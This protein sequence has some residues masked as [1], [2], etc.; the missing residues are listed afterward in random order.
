MSLDE[1]IDHRRRSPGPVGENSRQVMPFYRAIVLELER[2]RIALRISMDET[3][4]RA[5]IADRLYNKMVA[6]DAPS[7]RQ[8]RWETI[9]DVVDCLYPEGYDLEIRPRK[10]LRLGPGDLRCKI[11]FASASGGDTRSQRDLMRALG[12]LGGE[13]R[14]DK[15]KNMSSEERQRIAKKARKTRRQN[16]LLR[17]Q[18]KTERPESRPARS[19][20]QRAL[21]DALE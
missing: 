14:R 21:L 9:Q 18:Q 10:G 5:G 12:K 15:Y 6:A 4:D 19:A 1:I 3:S 2:R 20:P 13:A 11:A 16:R 7:G 8:S 17:A